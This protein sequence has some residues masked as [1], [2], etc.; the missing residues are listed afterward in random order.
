MACVRA[1]IHL[2]SS[3]LIF[4][5]ASLVQ[6]VPQRALVLLFTLALR[7]IEVRGIFFFWH[8]A[9]HF[10]LFSSSATIHSFFFLLS[11]AFF[12]VTFFSLGGELEG[13][14]RRERREG[15]VD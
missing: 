12:I 10:P 7:Y 1:A 8:A 11:S 13:R 5:S 14:E 2:S 3:L 9:F 4:T 15:R 6:P